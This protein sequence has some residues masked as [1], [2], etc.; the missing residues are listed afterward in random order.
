MKLVHVVNKLKMNLDKRA[1][2]Q[3]RGTTL[4]KRL[5]NHLAFAGVS[6]EEVGEFLVVDL[7]KHNI[8]TIKSYAQF[9]KYNNK[10]LNELVHSSVSKTSGQFIFTTSVAPFVQSHE[11]LMN[12]GRGGNLICYVRAIK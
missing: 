4:A 10:E 5:L 6:Y 1:L 8:Q 3:I 11:V 7:S 12:E 9:L 2:V